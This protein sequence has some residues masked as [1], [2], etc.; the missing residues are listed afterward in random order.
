MATIFQNWIE[1]IR[2]S[3]CQQYGLD[4]QYAMMIT[5]FLW[6]AFSNLSSEDFKDPAQFS[7]SRLTGIR[8]AYYLKTTQALT[9]FIQNNVG[10]YKND[11]SK[12]AAFIKWMNTAEVLFL[13]DCFEGFWVVMLSLLTCHNTVLEERLNA[14]DKNRFNRFMALLSPSNNF[15][16][17]RQHLK[18]QDGCFKPI[19]LWCRDLTGLSESE[20]APDDAESP[21]DTGA[22]KESLF[23]EIDSLICTN[24]TRLNSTCNLVVEDD[25][26][27]QSADHLVELIRLDLVHQFMQHHTR[28]VGWFGGEPRTV[29]GVSYT[30]PFGIAQIYDKLTHARTQAIPAKQVLLEINELAKSRQAIRHGFFNQRQT[31]THKFLAQCTDSISHLI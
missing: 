20:K 16:T 30:I 22:L 14:D 29:D 24:S 17:L 10:D 12:V 6:T 28:T 1:N 15:A 8:L 19:A 27:Q 31:I 7:L 5:S 25:I 21:V 18:K 23:K 3:S 11:T 4:R 13:N 26:S 2:T 9:V